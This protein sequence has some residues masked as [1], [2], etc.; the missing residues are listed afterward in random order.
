LPRRDIAKTSFDVAGLDRRRAI[1]VRQK[2]VTQPD[3][4]AA[5]GN[6]DVPDRHEAS[7]T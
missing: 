6:D 5:R 1:A 3:R 7:A 4:T 2:V